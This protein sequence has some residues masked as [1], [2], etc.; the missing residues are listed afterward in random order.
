MIREL[1]FVSHRQKYVAFAPQVFA[2]TRPGGGEHDPTG[3]L[4]LRNPI[5]QITRRNEWPVSDPAFRRRYC[6]YACLQ[7][8]VLRPGVRR[9][10][11]VHVGQE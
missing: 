11:S 1:A 9:L 5:A 4:V 7:G 3:A 8:G 2:S 10:S 6:R